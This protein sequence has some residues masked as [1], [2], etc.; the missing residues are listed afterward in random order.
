MS[1]IGIAPKVFRL[2]ETR[3]FA[4]EAEGGRGQTIGTFEAVRGV[5]VRHF[6]AR[7]TVARAL[8]GG[9]AILASPL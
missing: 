3:Y 8:A 4:L 9:G 7:E 6:S 5:R 1:C 2:A